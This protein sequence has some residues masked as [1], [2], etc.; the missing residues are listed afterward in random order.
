MISDNPTTT[1]TQANEPFKDIK[2]HPKYH[3]FSLNG[4]RLTSVTKFCSRFKEPF[5]RDGMSLKKAKERGVPQ[6]E[7]L[8]EW[9]AKGAAARAK[10]NIVHDHIQ[11]VLQGSESGRTDDQ[12]LALNETE[13]E[14][15][16]FD[17]LWQDRLS[18]TIDPVVC[19]WVVGDAEWGI[20]GIIDSVMVNRESGKF[21]LFDWKTNKEFTTR[22]NF[23]RRLLSPFEELDDCHLN[24]YS[25][26]ACLYWLILERNTDLSVDGGY[27]VHLS[28]DRYRIHQV[29]DLR[30]ELDRL[31]KLVGV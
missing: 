21:Y 28:P 13:P 25:L 19:E 7:I 20:G 3:Q 11:D 22:N 6:A 2:H 9:D 31:I 15:D 30:E 14:C 29:V 17:D 12:F 4:R 8:A 1:F 27:I 10:G 24:E 5:D 16:V 26:Q 23:G 18:K